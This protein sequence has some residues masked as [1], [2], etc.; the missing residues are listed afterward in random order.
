MAAFLCSFLSLTNVHLFDDVGVGNRYCTLWSPF[1][2]GSRDGRCCV[3]KWFIHRAPFVCNIALLS[4]LHLQAELQSRHYFK[5]NA[6]IALLS[7]LNYISLVRL[8]N[9]A[10]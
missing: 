10:F 4:I 6:V 5:M 1:N 9:C 7:V 3:R 2:R 8:L